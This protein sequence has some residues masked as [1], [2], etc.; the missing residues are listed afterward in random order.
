MRFGKNKSGFTLHGRSGGNRSTQTFESISPATD[1]LQDVVFGAKYLANGKRVGDLNV[2]V[3]GE[4]NSGFAGLYD[5]PLNRIDFMGMNYPSKPLVKNS[6]WTVTVAGQSYVPN[7]EMIETEDHQTVDYHFRVLDIRRVGKRTLVDVERM[8]DKKLKG[9]AW[10]VNDHYVMDIHELDRI[11]IDASDGIV[12][13]ADYHTVWTQRQ[14]S[15]DE[16]FLVVQK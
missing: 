4:P 1:P 13:E 9:F 12:V 5:D 6:S 14:T 11:T 16:R 10:P 8:V 15:H 3:A 2:K 7:G